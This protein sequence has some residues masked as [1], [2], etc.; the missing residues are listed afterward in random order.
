MYICH[1]GAHTSLSKAGKGKFFS[2]IRSER[3]AECISVM[4]EAL[5][6]KQINRIIYA[7]LK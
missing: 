2:R 3:P 1:V 4:A 7:P 5:E 6:S